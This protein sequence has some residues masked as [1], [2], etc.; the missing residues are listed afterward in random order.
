MRVPSQQ[1]SL[2][3][4]L[5]VSGLGVLDGRMGWGTERGDGTGDGELLFQSRRQIS[6]ASERLIQSLR[7]SSALPALPILPGDDVREGPEQRAAALVFIFTPLCV[8][9][10][11][12]FKHNRGN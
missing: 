2:R 6:A 7:L 11:F 5:V 12:L 3:N 4:R 10:P 8:L 1:L 9:S